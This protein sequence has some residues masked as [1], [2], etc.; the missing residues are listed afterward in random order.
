MAAAKDIRVAR[1]LTH[2]LPSSAG[3][4]DSAL[5]SNVLLVLH[6]GKDNRDSASQEGRRLHQKRRLVLEEARKD[7]KNN[8]ERSQPEERSPLV[9]ETRANHDG[10]EDQGREIC[11]HDVRQLSLGGAHD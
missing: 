1:L 7:Q 4:H 2:D 6:T 3:L 5:S 9:N 10:C 8:I 11:N